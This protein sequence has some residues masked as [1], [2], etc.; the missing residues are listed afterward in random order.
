[1]ATW[2]TLEHKR[3]HQD[4]REGCLKVEPM[5]ETTLVKTC[6]LIWNGGQENH[7]FILAIWTHGVLRVTVLNN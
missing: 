3:T 6:F 4:M 1:M 7:Q 2:K 5:L